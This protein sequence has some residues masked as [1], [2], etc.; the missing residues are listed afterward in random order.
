MELSFENVDKFCASINLTDASPLVD[1]SAYTFFKPS[2]LIYLGQYLRYHSA[3]GIKFKVKPPK[4]KIATTYLA[5][6]RFWHRFDVN[7]ETMPRERLQF[8]DDNT[9]LN[10]IIDIENRPNIAEEIA[11]NV[12]RVLL[13]NIVHIDNITVVEIVTELI[14]NFAQHSEALLATLLMQYYPDRHEIA[15][16]VGDGGIGIRASL[17]KNPKYEYLAVLPHYE[18]ALKAFEPMTGRT[19][20]R[21]VGLTYVRE[22][23]LKAQGRMILITGDGYVKINREKTEMG[24]MVYNLGGVQIEVVIP[25]KELI[26]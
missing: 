11:S 12:L 23:V 6:Q 22:Q 25:E 4:D 17:S 15:I 2:A 3:K 21:G 13:K 7:L 10:D 24:T 19:D 5:Q 14:D 20:E 9:S 8:F 1:L 26:P 16:G 18:A